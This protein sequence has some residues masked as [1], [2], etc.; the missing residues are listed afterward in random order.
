MKNRFGFK[1]ILA[2]AMALALLF[3]AP[4]SDNVGVAIAGEYSS[5][6]AE[7]DIAK[8]TAL[9]YVGTEEGDLVPICSAVAFQRVAGNTYYFLTAAECI[10]DD[11]AMEEFG[12]EMVELIPKMDFYLTFNEGGPK[13][14]YPAKM[15]GFFGQNGNDAQIM[16]LQ[17]TLFRNIPVFPLSLRKLKTG[18]SVINYAAMENPG[19]P[20]RKGK[21]VKIKFKKPV[22]I[23]GKKKPGA[24]LLR[25]G[26][27]V[28][29]PDGMVYDPVIISRDRKVVVAIL[30]GQTKYRGSDKAVAIPITVDRIPFSPPPS[31]N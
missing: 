8:A 25:M 14:F 30:I 3:I 15:V 28:R 20:T 4:L 10:V 18:E 27:G 29:I 12:Q 22:E 16:I 19:K 23:D 13:L 21:V 11:W 17:A 7:R 26:K 9:L 1:W 5:D 6:Q 31:D 24:V 2:L